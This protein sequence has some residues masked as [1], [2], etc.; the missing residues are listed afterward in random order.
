MRKTLLFVLV[1]GTLTVGAA[2]AG[3]S[4]LAETTPQPPNLSCITERPVP[5]LRVLRDCENDFV[6]PP[7]VPEPYLTPS[8]IPIVGPHDGGRKADRADQ[9]EAQGGAGG[10][11]GPNSVD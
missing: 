6:P 8:Q 4:A 11:G 5:N 3:K 2:D 7:P 1:A 9:N 10:T